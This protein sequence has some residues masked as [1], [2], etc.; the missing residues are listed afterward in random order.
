MSASSIGS[1]L[2][3]ATLVGAMMKP[4]EAKVASYSKKISNYNLQISEFSKIKD[5]FSKLQTSIK[6]VEKNQI[7]DLPV[8]DLKSALQSFVDNYNSAN[9]I[10][11][12]STN[13][14]IK[15]AFSSV[16]MSLDP[17]VSFQLGISFDKT[18][19]ASFDSS[20]IDKI[21]ADEAN[22]VFVSVN[23]ATVTLDDMVNG[24]FDKVIPATSTFNYAI[25]VNGSISKRIQSLESQVDKM[26]REQF[27]EQD[28][29]SGYRTMY[30]KKFTNLQNM[31][32]RLSTI[33]N[34]MTGYT[35]MLNKN[36]G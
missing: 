5:S 36:N 24:F 22:G 26:E 21:V 13:Y 8:A 1:N 3:V 10:S 18:G 32:D 19:V 28:K 25:D 6:N 23:G 9:S 35:N 17:S 20:K 16:R 14:N 29:L 2:D 33:E 4:H 15:S 27:A 7:T 30:T 34:S 31:L 11:K 12:T